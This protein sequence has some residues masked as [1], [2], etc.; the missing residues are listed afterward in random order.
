MYK[1][2]DT[3]INLDYTRQGKI[4]TKYLNKNLDQVASWSN[5]QSKVR[6][7]INIQLKIQLRQLAQAQI[8]D[9]KI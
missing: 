1:I 8:K 2:P 4:L 7:I 3:G 5:N 6:F 9:N